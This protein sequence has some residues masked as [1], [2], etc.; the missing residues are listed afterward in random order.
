METRS[1]KPDI[2]DRAREAWHDCTKD[3]FS[4]LTTLV[5]VLATIAFFYWI[6]VGMYDGYRHGASECAAYANGVAGAPCERPL[7]Q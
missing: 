5:W 7:V 3:R 1:M 2:F 6:G 4:A